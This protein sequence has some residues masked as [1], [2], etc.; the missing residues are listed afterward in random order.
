MDI[1]HH[2]VRGVIG[3]VHGSN[4]IHKTSTQFKTPEDLFLSF[5][6][7]HSARGASLP[8]VAES[9]ISKSEGKPFPSEK[10]PVRADEG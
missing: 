1:S 8:E 10:V 3:V 4:S 7:S 6:A 5:S 9:T 2:I